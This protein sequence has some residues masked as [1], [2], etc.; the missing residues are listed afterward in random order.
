MLAPLDL[1]QQLLVEPVD[2]ARLF[3]AASDQR[4]I[5]GQ[6]QRIGGRLGEV[7]AGSGHGDFDPHFAPVEQDRLLDHGQDLVSEIHNT[8]CPGFEEDGEFGATEAA[9]NG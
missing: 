1:G 5:G 3:G 4:G 6:A 8:A 2:T 7:G 9:G